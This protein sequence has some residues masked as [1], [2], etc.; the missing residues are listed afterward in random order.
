M[1]RGST[2]LS[3]SLLV[4]LCALLSAP[5]S[6]SAQEAGPTSRPPSTDTGPVLPPIG[7]T[8]GSVSETL[9][10]LLTRALTS[11]ESSDQTLLSLKLRIEE[12]E[13]QR[14]LDAEQRRREQEESARAYSLLSSRVAVLQ[15]YSDRLLPL[16]TDFAGSEDEKYERAIRAVGEIRDRAAALERQN[17]FL[18]WAAGIGAGLAVAAAAYA[19]GRAAGWW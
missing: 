19:G 8:E 1:W 5:C 7:L 14:R 16:L 12:D 13:R 15:S 11:S 17:R 9:K 3:A 10:L 4:L 2:R 18:K 6:S